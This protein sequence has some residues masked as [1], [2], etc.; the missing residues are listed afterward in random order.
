MLSKDDILKKLSAEN[1]FIDKKSLEVFISD[2]KI[3]P[4]FED[5]FGTEFYDDFSVKKIRKGITLKAQGYSDESIAEKIIEKPAI[6]KPQEQELVEHSLTTIPESTGVVET[7]A[8]PKLRNL[9]LD[10]SSQTLQMIADAVAHKITDDIK[11]SDFAK[12]LIEAGSYKRDNEILS[13]QIAELLEDN[14]KMAER[15]EALESKKSFWQKLFC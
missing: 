11:N 3:N 1:Y 5:E 9:T 14:K 15:I 10:I 6:P 12:D 13:K 7:P 8:S 4:V 2:W